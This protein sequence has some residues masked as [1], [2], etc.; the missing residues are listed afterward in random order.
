MEKK[1]NPLKAAMAKFFY[2]GNFKTAYFLEIE[3][4]NQGLL[5]SICNDLLELLKDNINYSCLDMH[6]TLLRN[7]LENGIHCNV[8]YGETNP[9]LQL[10]IAKSNNEYIE[11]F[12]DS[13]TEEME[14]NL[15][16]LGVRL[17]KTYHADGNI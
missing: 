17:I 4:F 7:I 10:N 11:L 1:F 8:Y 12:F 9:S 3:A 2:E 16:N 15:K 14:E 5:R 6:N 13:I